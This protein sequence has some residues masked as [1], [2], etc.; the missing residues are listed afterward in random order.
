VCAQ[1][2]HCC[3]LEANRPRVESA[4]FWIASERSSVTP[5]IGHVLDDNIFIMGPVSLKRYFLRSLLRGSAWHWLPLSWTTADAKARRVLRARDA[6]AEFAMH[7]TASTR[8]PQKALACEKRSR[9]RL[10]Y[11]AP[12][13]RGREHRGRRTPTLFKQEGLAVASI[14]RDDPSTLPGDDPF[15]RA[16]MHRDCNAR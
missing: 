4:T 12:K 2:V 16:R 5:H 15:P 1:L 7:Y 6:G 13:L 10:S 11:P 3:Y 9:V 8:C 14:A